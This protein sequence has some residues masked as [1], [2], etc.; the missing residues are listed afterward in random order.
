[1]AKQLLMLH[2]TS[3][4]PLTVFLETQQKGLQWLQSLGIPALHLWSCSCIVVQYLAVYLLNQLLQVQLSVHPNELWNTLL[5]TWDR[6][7][8]NIQIHTPT[9]L[10]GLLS[11]PTRLMTTIYSFTSK[12]VLSKFFDHMRQIQSTHM[13]K[14]ISYPFSLILMCANGL[15]CVY[16]PLKLLEAFGGRNSRETQP[17]NFK[18]CQS[19]AALYTVDMKSIQS[20]VA[21]VPHSIRGEARP[22]AV[23]K[24]GLDAGI[25][26][27]QTEEDNDE[28]LL[29][30]NVG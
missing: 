15:D 12:T 25:M 17:L 4:D 29:Q 24:R 20:V 27:G 14:H 3:Q 23:E 19:D 11:V 5:A 28:A 13:L 22:F 6:K 7:S 18:T 2:N 21:M 1:M 26:A 30:D 8:G 16:L 10:R 9:Y